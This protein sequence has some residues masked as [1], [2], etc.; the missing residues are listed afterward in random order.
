MNWK[1]RINN[2][3]ALDKIWSNCIYVYWKANPYWE[4]STGS[5]M[6][7]EMSEQKHGSR[8]T[9]YCMLG[10]D[11]RIFQHEVWLTHILTF[12]S[13]RV[14]ISTHI[15]LTIFSRCESHCEQNSFHIV[16]HKRRWPWK[17]SH[18]L[19]TFLELFSKKDEIFP[20]RK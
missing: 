18:N 4:Q 6:S 5:K 11:Y 20:Q 15:F 12:K 8:D 2:L 9:R 1:R 3:F 10:H 19:F 7:F 17:Y 14:F 13:L 16:P